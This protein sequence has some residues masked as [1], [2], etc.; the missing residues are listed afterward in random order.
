MNDDV[1]SSIINQTGLLLLE[2]AGRNDGKS[3]IYAEVEPGMYSVS[4]FVVR[5]EVVY[6][7]L[8]PESI[9][10][11][12][13]DLWAAADQDKKWRAVCYKLIGDQVQV[14]FDYGEGWDEEEISFDRRER[15]LEEFYKDR[16]IVYPT[17]G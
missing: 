1:V 13:L 9:V 7:V 17:I 14:T 6:Y 16:T 5:G 2:Q 15:V 8:D 12:I 4:V 10:T 11:A 3:M